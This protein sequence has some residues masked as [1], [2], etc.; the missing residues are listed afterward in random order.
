MSLMDYVVVAG[1]IVTIVVGAIGIPLALKPFRLSRNLERAKVY[2]G[3]KK[4]LNAVSQLSQAPNDV[5]NVFHDATEE[6][7][8]KLLFSHEDARAYIALLRTKANDLRTLTALK[9][10]LPDGEKK[11]S[12]TLKWLDLVQWMEQQRSSELEKRLGR[13][14]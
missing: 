12:V 13:Y 6:K 10:S 3:I 9:T 8:V 11:S 1:V 7:R 5:L 2:D 14:L 4:Y